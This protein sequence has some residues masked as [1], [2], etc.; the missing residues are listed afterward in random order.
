[1]N[2]NYVLEP[3]DELLQNVLAHGFDIHDRTGVG[4]RFLPG[5]SMKIDIS[6]RVPIL[7]RR[8]TNWKSMLG[9]YLWFLSGSDKISDL[10]DKFNS[11]VWNFWENKEWAE[12]KGYDPSSIGYGYGPNLINYGG[13]IEDDFSSHKSGVN[14][15]QYVLDELRENPNSRRAM[16]SF[17]RPDKLNDTVLPPCH[18]LYQWMV[19]DGKISCSMYCR[20]QDLFVGTGSTNLQG[21]T[22]YTY[23]I[24]QQLELKP[25][26]L[27]WHAGHAHI[28]HN[29]FGGVLEYLS[30]PVPNS[31]KLSLLKKDSLWDYGVDD[32][33]L[34]D[35]NPLDRIKVEVAV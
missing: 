12:E 25:D 9:E 7:T 21:A 20:S 16:V 35:Y 34:E 13:N 33:V 14:Q 4:C 27:F 18:V 23:M 11:K 22:F 2:D 5:R 6:K 15:M 32:F 17:W 30:R 28:Y 26:K 19:Y 8:K 1:M 24:A 29:H 31:P 3:Y 10:R